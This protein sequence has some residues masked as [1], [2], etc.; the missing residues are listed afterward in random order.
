M[1]TRD[2]I[3]YRGW[4]FWKLVTSKSLTDEERRKIA[5]ALSVDQ[6]VL[7]NRQNA[8]GQQHGYRVFQHLVG[9]GVENQDLLVAALLHDVGKIRYRSYWWYRPIVVVFGYLFPMQ[10]KKWG[11]SDRKGWRRPFVIR[12][13]H[14]LWGAEYAKQAGCSRVTVDLILHHQDSDGTNSNLAEKTLLDH[15]R[16]ADNKS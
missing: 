12:E 5:N 4:Q 7:F 6:M 9:E 16:Q 13:N 11:K 3:A 1:G 2:R 14:A 8:A 15:L 10:I